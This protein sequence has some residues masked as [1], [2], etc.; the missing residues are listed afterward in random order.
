VG[1]AAEVGDG[2]DGSDPLPFDMCWRWIADGV[3]VVGVIASMG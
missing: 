1:V 3:G 2:S